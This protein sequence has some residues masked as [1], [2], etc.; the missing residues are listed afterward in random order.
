MPALRLA[1]WHEGFGGGAC[2]MRRG[3]LLVAMPCVFILNCIV[4]LA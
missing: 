2:S 4:D 1:I 3:L